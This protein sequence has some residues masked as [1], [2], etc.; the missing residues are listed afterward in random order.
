MQQGMF[1]LCLSGYLV[2]QVFPL[3]LDIISINILI[4]EV[5]ES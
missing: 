4:H 5:N 3:I 1:E 2:F